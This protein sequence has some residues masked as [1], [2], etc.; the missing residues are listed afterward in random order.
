MAEEVDRYT[1]SR[2]WGVEENEEASPQL[3]DIWE[4]DSEWRG[5]GRPFE[6]GLT[7]PSGSEMFLQ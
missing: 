7:Q 5:S 4:G 6:S 1:A 2:V 3:R